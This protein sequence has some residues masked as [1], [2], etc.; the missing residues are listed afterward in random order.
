[1]MN[2][3]APDSG[4]AQ[5]T[6]KGDEES[7]LQTPGKASLE[8]ASPS[9]P[10]HSAVGANPMLYSKLILRKVF[11]IVSSDE[12]E[13]APSAANGYGIITLLKDVTIGTVFGVLTIS[14]LIFLDHINVIHLQSAHNFRQSA[15]SVVNDPETLATLEESAGLKFIPVSD[16]N[17]MKSE[18][19][20][21]TGKVAK[22]KDTMAER[23]KETEEKKA[24]L[25]PLQ[26][27]Y[28][29][30]LKESTLELDKW[31][32]ECSWMGGT[33]CDSRKQ[34]FMDQY[35]HTEI[36]SKVAIM[37]QSPGCKKKD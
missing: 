30:L 21:A 24:E 9:S 33:S 17:A 1:M 2:R 18:I 15:F 16:Y 7:L 29:K 35:G 13:T 31:C 26:A 5:P 23:I 11:A 3:R 34:Y 32:G 36:F 19:E 4:G 20:A 10:P 22:V 6:R 8:P 27:E 28:E 25:G 14:I 37:K 12:D